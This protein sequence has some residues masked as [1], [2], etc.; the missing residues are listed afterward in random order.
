MRHPRHL[1]SA[2]LLALAMSILMASSTLAANIFTAVTPAY[3]GYAAFSSSSLI[4]VGVQAD[5]VV[6]TKSPTS[7]Y[8]NETTLY[9]IGLGMPGT[10]KF[11]GVG[12]RETLAR[13]AS[14]PVFKI[15]ATGSSSSLVVRRGDAIHMYTS[16][17]RSTGLANFYVYNKTTAKGWSAL[18]VV[19]SSYYDG[20]HASFSLVMNANLDD[21][22]IDFGSMTYTNVK[23]QNPIGTANWIALGAESSLVKTTLADGSA[24]YPCAIPSALLSSTSFRIDEVPGQSC[25]GKG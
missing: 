5:F 21:H 12:V 23:I 3:A 24:A 9:V 6:P 1:L 16:Y 15:V 4:A 22:L 18:Y 8:E 2:S 10:N 17:Q 7:D 14:I 20:Y 19:P 11:I 13:Y 25:G